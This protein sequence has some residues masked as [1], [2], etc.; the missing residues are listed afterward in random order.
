MIA[1]GSGPAP[2]A[3]FG[4]GILT[5]VNFLNYM[6][7]L[8]VAGAQPYIIR[9][10]DLSDVE[11]GLI[12]SIFVIVYMIASPLGGILGD[13]MPRR[14][15]VA[16]S[17]GL[18]SLATIG[19]GLAGTFITFLIARAIIGI[20]EAGYGAVAPAIIS[21]L[22]PRN[23]RTRMLSFF[24]TAIPVGAAAG[25]A[26]GGYLAE[27]VSW[28]AAFFVGGAPG[29]VVAVATLFM[30][31][32]E[33][34]ATEE[35]PVEPKVPFLQG[36]KALGP[37]RVYWFTTAGYTLMT[38]AV[39]GLASWMPTFL[40]RERG[41]PLGEAG[42]AFGAMTALGG[43]FGTVAGG[44]LGD[45]ADRR[46]S[47]GG[48]RVSAAGLLL[49]APF[50]IGAATFQVPLLIYASAFLAQFFLFLNSGP[51]NATIVNCVAPSFRAFAMGLNVLLIHLLGDALSPM[52]IG[53][54]SQKSSLSLAIILNAVPVVLGAVVLYVGSTQRMLPTSKPTLG[55]V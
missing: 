5:L 47:G 51:I 19:S 43:L 39:G 40:F 23:Q 29:L 48:L 15:L 34:G 30:P 16:A 11:A 13:R 50:M 27:H 17:V 32:P 53:F 55:T 35:G 8:I 4:L 9:E 31:E 28:H 2:R 37:N 7:R 25:F 33:R 36:V 22:Y 42:L 52:V 20:G 21:D 44:Y 38:F 6:D 10:F 49:C 41:I 54:I 3:A 1:P 24:Y 18:W 12:T 14:F 26:V 45:W 46:G